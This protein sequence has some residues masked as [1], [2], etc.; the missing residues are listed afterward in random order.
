MRTPP[1]FAALVLSAALAGPGAAAPRPW[2]SDDILALKTVSDP[3]LS[4]DGRWVAYVVSELNHD[5]SEYQTDV[6]LA[7]TAG[8]EARRLTGSP[9]AD[10]FPRWSPDGRTVAFLSERPRPNAKKDDA[11]KDAGTDEAKRQIWM[12]RPDGGEA[13]QLSDAKGGVSALEWSRDGAA[14][15]YL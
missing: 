9:A 2:T 8:G 6:W 13:W 5:G 12:I 15:A 4:P 7:P 11:S 10:E 3:R 1:I 14:I